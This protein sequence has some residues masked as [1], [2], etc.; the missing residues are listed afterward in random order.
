MSFFKQFPKIDYDFNRSGTIQQMVNIFR[1]V[2]PLNTML[3]NSTLYKTYN[4]KDGERPDVVSQQLY[5]TSDYY[6]SFFVLNDF[7]H[8]GLQSWPM[9]QQQLTAYINSNYS[10]KALQF[11]SEVFNDITHNSVAGKLEIGGLVYGMS[12]GSV[13][14]IVRK[15][16]DLNMIVLQD[17]IVGS[18]NR[19]PITGQYDT[20][21]VGPASRDQVFNEREFLQSFW[22]AEVGRPVSANEKLGISVA[23]GDTVPQSSSLSPCKVYNYSEAPAFYYVDGDPD[24]RPITSPIVI[25]SLEAVG[26]ITSLFSELQWNEDLQNQVDGFSNNLLNNTTQTN[27]IATNAGVAT[28]LIYS[29][30]YRTGADDFPGDITFKSNR[31]FIIQRNEERS[32]IRVINPTY[33]EE[34][35]EEFESLINA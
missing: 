8:D 5:K 12:S 13:G 34:F 22:N 35:I 3:N 15:D 26:D 33:I 14:R 29:G 23:V 27:Y 2:R 28:P 17:L 18:K 4:I 32:N 20:S 31:E 11:E 21:I 16:V 10:G 24:E 1:S 25:Q 7:L 19:N 9:S 30:G 6:W